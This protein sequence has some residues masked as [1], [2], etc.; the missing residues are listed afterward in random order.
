MLDAV[1]VERATDS[2]RYIAE[3]SIKDTLA[4][5]TDAHKDN[6]LAAVECKTCFYL[7][8]GRAGGSAI[9]TTNCRV[10]DEDISFPS[11]NVDHLCKQ[12]GA[13]QE[14][15]VRCGGDLH[16]RPRRVYKKIDSVSPARVKKL[17]DLVKGVKVDLS[18]RLDPKDD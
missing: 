6:R 12:C 8:S 14:L 17:K 7:R 9:T 5:T 15:C 16:M 11:T 2:A 13:V 10:C 1:S 3:E 18:K 4:F